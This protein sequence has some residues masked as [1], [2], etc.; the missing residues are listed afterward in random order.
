MTT[1][2][3]VIAAFGN[4]QE[5]QAQL[6]MQIA[7][8][9]EL[10][11]DFALVDLIAGGM[12]FTVRTADGTVGA[13]LVSVRQGIGFVALQFDTISV[14]GADAPAAYVESIS[15]ELPALII[16]SLDVLFAEQVNAGNIWEGMTVTDGAITAT[17]VEP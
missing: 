11:I 2:I 4:E 14:A 13:V 1:I 8:H 17:F 3:P 15:R 6:D 5:F 12:N 10:D 16:D 9:P 7:A